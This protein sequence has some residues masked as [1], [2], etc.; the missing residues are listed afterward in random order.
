LL[1]K[2]W[3]ATRS[4]A[5]EYTR[6][7]RNAKLYLFSF[8]LSGFSFAGFILFFNFYLHSLHYDD[9]VIGVLNAMPNICGVLFGI[10]AGYLGDRVGHKRMLIGG[11]VIN[12]A[13]FIGFSMTGSLPMLSLLLFVS[14]FGL[15]I[16]WT[17]A[18]PFM[19]DNS[20]EAER[21][22]LFSLQFALSTLV[23]FLGSIGM[24]FMPSLWAGWLK[25]RPDSTEALRATLLVA[26][27][28]LVLSVIPLLFLTEQPHR[29]RAAERKQ[30]KG[31]GSNFFLRNPGLV[32]RLMLPSVLIG[33][34]AGLTI[35]FLN[36]FVNSKFNIEYE[37]LGI[38]FGFADLS[39][40][41]AIFIQPLLARRFG[42][43]RAVVMFQALSLPFL[44]VL[45]F[46]PY[47]WMVAI[48]LYVRGALMQAANPVY[49]V[50]M[51]EQVPV[52]KRATMA[53]IMMVSDNLARGGGSIFSGF[54]RGSVGQMAG[55]NMLFGLMICSYIGS[56][57]LFYF[58][59]RH[60][61]ETPQV[62]EVG[63][64]QA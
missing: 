33:M 38:L 40:T 5:L 62:R 21:T 50:F 22:Q 64:A 56:I 36:I 52:E 4:Y 17:L 43:V 47:F 59:F 41:M 15:T 23:N 34:G 48:A 10:P 25:V 32:M 2:L 20:S 61:E 55:F 60:R 45:G 11:T 35:P 26:G 13:G 3:K 19:A 31:K 16:T 42:K 14:S 1:P 46:A 53:G 30:A 54:L 57:G 58:S 39:T 49:M 18:A 37:S 29:V 12:T 8:F 28:S 51:Q 27:A 9:G 24:G 7:S 63:S 44:V 6:F